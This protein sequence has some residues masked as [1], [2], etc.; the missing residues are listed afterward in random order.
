[1]NA[2]RRRRSLRPK[3]LLLLLP[4]LLF[5]PSSV[6]ASDIGPPLRLLT[7]G[8]NHEELLLQGTVGYDSRSYGE[9]G[10][11]GDA[12]VSS[13]LAE[14]RAVVP[15]AD[16]WEVEGRF[17]FLQLDTTVSFGG[18]SGGVN[19]TYP[20]LGGGVRTLLWQDN[21]ALGW[22][23]GAAFDLSVAML[24][25]RSGTVSSPGGGSVR[26]AVDKPWEARLA[27]PVSRVVVPAPYLKGDWLGIDR[28]AREYYGGPFLRLSRLPVKARGVNDS[29]VGYRASADLGGS[30]LPGL[31]GGVRWVR[32]VDSG[33]RSFGFEAQYKD[34]FDISFY[35]DLSF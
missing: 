7:A 9:G 2:T 29:G 6:R 35:G 15:A 8:E 13:V 16:G 32:R 23:V 1:M 21:A 22:R 3:V 11:F 19:A 4:L 26:F 18:L 30:G 5:L 31:F 12:D 33:E 14:G 17:G 25:F 10:G 34:G 20:V 24:D 28:Y 27:L